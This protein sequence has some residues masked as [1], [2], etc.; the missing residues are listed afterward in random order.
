MR[1][2][3]PY[4]TYVV[5]KRCPSRLKTFKFFGPIQSYMSRI[6]NGDALTYAKLFGCSNILRRLPEFQKL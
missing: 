1:R 2:H 5:E 3:N 6:D 4:A